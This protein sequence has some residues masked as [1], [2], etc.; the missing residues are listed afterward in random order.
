MEY[1]RNRLGLLTFIEL[2][3]TLFIFSINQALLILDSG[4]LN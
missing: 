1:L 4:S 2:I 3:K